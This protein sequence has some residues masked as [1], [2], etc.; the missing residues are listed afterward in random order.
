MFA[1]LSGKILLASGIDCDIK[2]TLICTR[3]AIELDVHLRLAGE[4]DPEFDWHGQVAPVARNQVAEASREHGGKPTGVGD[5][6][7]ASY[8]VIHGV[9]EQLIAEFELL[10]RRNRG[11]GGAELLAQ[12]IPGLM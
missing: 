5:R 2:T 1:D 6:G 9:D 7:C 10:A 3:R 11:N 4:G 12:K 8:G